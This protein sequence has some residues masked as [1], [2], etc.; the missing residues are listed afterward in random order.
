VKQIAKLLAVMFSVLALL[1]YVA[2]AEWTL[3]LLIAAAIFLAADAN[4]PPGQ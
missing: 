2:G 4:I 3:P 1:S